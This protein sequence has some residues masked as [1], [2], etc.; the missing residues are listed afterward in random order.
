[1]SQAVERPVKLLILLS[2]FF[3]AELFFLSNFANK[4]YAYEIPNN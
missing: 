1:M 4:K 3:C 2:N